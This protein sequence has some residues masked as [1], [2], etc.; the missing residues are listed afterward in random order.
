MIYKGTDDYY[1]M[2][3][4]TSGGEPALGGILGGVSANLFGASALG[5]DTWTHLA[6]TYDGTTMRLY[7]NGLQVASQASAGNI[8]T[9]ANPLQI[10]GDSIFGQTFEGKIDEVRVYDRALSV[11]E[12][13]SDMNTPVAGGPS[14]QPLLLSI[15]ELPDGSFVIAGQVYA[16]R[17]YRFQYK[18]SLLDSNWTDLG[19]NQTALSSRVAI[20]NNANAMSQRFYRLLDVAAP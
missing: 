7:V 19:A 17:T 13:Q 6:G 14:S 20:T 8:L 10:G 5:L 16:G 15:S 3:T 1:L 2:G 12:I 18:N 11:S 4:T 9:S